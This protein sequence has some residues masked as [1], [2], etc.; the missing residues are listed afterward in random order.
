MRASVSCICQYHSCWMPGD[1]RNQG[2]S[3]HGI[4]IVIP[5]Y[6]CFSTRRTTENSLNETTNR[7]KITG[8]NRIYPWT[9]LIKNMS[10]DSMCFGT[11]P[12][13]PQPTNYLN[14]LGG[15]RVHTF[16]INHIVRF[17]SCLVVP[18]YPILSATSTTL[19][20]A[21]IPMRPCPK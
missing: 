21:W 14:E 19:R 8:V 15:I 17:F 6:L 20:Q 12:F 9:K 4:D 1:A 16:G 3:S 13:H 18:A 2:I 7:H 11:G 10:T 5:E